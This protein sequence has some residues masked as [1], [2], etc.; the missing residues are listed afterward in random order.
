MRLR[1][2]DD[3]DPAIALP[4]GF[5]MILAGWFF[6]AAALHIELSRKESTSMSAQ[7]VR[8]AIAI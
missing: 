7:P 2:R 6:F 5:V 3:V 8:A 1:Q 4:A